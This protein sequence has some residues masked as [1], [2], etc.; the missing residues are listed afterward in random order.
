MESRHVKDLITKFD[1]HARNRTEA[2]GT[3]AGFENGAL[4]AGEF[5][6]ELG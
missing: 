2:G 5:A 1:D 3:M 4:R 6:A